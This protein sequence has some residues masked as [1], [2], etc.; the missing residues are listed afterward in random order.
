MGGEKSLR[1]R[2]IADS[3]VARGLDLGVLS[4][5]KKHA[6]GYYTALGAED[7]TLEGG[8]SFTRHPSCPA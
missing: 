6:L 5:S 3:P 8:G 1:K 4:L 7:R 2:R